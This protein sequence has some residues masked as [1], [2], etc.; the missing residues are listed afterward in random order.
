MRTFFYEFHSGHVGGYGVVVAD[1]VSDALEL[2]NHSIVNEPLAKK[3]QLLLESD[4]K[5][6]RPNEA[7]VIYNGEY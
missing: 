3:G 4:L 1:N 6:V 5:E 2:A 7:C